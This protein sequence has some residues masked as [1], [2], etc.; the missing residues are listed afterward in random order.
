MTIPLDPQLLLMYVMGGYWTYGS[1]IDDADTLR[2]RLA[3]ITSAPDIYIKLIA[4]DAGSHTGIL[5][6]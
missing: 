2:V 6:F 4:L 3:P 5:A 1:V